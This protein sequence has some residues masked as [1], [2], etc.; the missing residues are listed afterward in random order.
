[1]W[2]DGG[3]LY[4]AIR[5]EDLTGNNRT[6]RRALVDGAPILVTPTGGGAS[7]PGVRKRGF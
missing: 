6:I 4:Y 3:C 1:M 2:G 5:A 7:D